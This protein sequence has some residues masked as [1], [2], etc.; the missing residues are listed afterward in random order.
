MW[1]N[2]CLVIWFCRQLFYAA[3]RKKAEDSDDTD[4]GFEAIVE[5][6]DDVNTENNADALDDN[7]DMSDAESDSGETS[8]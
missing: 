8:D 1:S 7:D 2:P 6:G 5:T 3:A 4:H